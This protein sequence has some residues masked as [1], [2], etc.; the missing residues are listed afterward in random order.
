MSDWKVETYA[1][2]FVVEAKVVVSENKGMQIQCEIY[3][4]ILETEVNRST[5]N[6]GT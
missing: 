6:V 2:S 1:S 4:F 3:A 5:I